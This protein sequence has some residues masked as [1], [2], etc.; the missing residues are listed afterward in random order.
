[1]LNEKNRR[2]TEE[3]E[4]AT[5]MNTFFDN[6]ADRLDIK[7]GNDSSL[8]SINFQNM[9][10]VLENF[11]NYPGVHTIRQTFMT[12]KNF[13]FEFVSKDVVRKK[14]MNLDASKI[15]PNG[16]FSINIL[17]ST[18]DIH[19]PYLANIIN[20]SIEEDHFLMNLSL[21]KFP[22]RKMTQTR[23]ITGLTV[24]YLIKQNA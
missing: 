7:K 3:K 9:N 6:I 20:L 22:K 21:K 24:P 8:N 19:L 4:L 12:D 2:I 10:D 16:D 15:T 11:K 23:R 17:K 1:M 13:S 18:F 5:V 14:I